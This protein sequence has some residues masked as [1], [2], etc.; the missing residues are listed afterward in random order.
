MNERGTLPASLR[1]VY[2]A[3]VSA[4]ADS[5]RVEAALENGATC[6]WLRDP[7]ANGRALYDAA[8][9]LVLRCRRAGAAVLV[10]DRADVALAV[11]ADG[12]QL[13]RRAPPARTVRPWYR[14]R[15]G[16]SCHSREEVRAAED[17]GADHVVVSPIF[18]V[19]S[20]GPP[21]GV[22]WLADLVRT[23]RVPVVA[24]GGIE[25]ENV[26]QV[27]ATGVAGVAV[28]RAIREA[29]DP[30]GAAKALSRAVTSR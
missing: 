30:A 5:D 17:S 11:G 7:D 18:G 23:T 21:L 1:L 24:L 28:I 10:G 27:L 2:V 12:V 22:E 9:S 14:D 3:S 16:V 25:P 26:D 8:G 20:K 4:V 19:P 13:G 6:V 29:R 15:L